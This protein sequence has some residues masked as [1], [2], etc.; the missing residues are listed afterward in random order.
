MCLCCVGSHEAALSAARW[1]MKQVPSS[2]RY[3]CTDEQWRE[4]ERQ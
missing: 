3:A 1:P 2:V 4:R